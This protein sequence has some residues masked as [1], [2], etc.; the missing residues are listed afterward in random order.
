MVRRYYQGLRVAPPASAVA[1]M[2]LRVM[3]S[4]RSWVFT[5]ISPRLPGLE[6]HY[7]L[8]ARPPCA[9]FVPLKTRKPTRHWVGR[10]HYSLHSTL[11]AQFRW[12]ISAS[13]RQLICLRSTQVLGSGP[14]Y[15]CPVLD[16]SIRKCTYPHQIGSR[17]RRSVNPHDVLLMPAGRAPGA[18]LQARRSHR[19]RWPRARDTRSS[20]A[21]SRQARIQRVVRRDPPTLTVTATR[22]SR[23]VLANRQRFL[24]P[25]T[26]SGGAAN[27]LAWSAPPGRL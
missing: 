16:G 22:V 26:T 3:A 27:P 1:A 2:A 6:G 17:G 4:R 7:R 25:A 10:L 23:R 8:H 9:V 13:E 11:S 24:D 21:R 18:N 19:S 5:D 14:D 15:R 12:G 20:H